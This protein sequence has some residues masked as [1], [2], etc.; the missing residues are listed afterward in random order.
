MDELS[1]PAFEESSFNLKKELGYYL[2]FWPYLLA[3]VL[4]VLIGSF[5]YLRYQTPI[6]SGQA[7]IQI[8][9]GKDD[10]SAFLTQGVSLFGYDRIKLVNEI[11]IITSNFMLGRVVDRVGLQT[12]VYV[13]GSIRESLQD[14][15]KLPFEV[16]FHN[17]EARA[18]FFI[19]IENSKVSVQ[20]D[21]VVLD[22]PSN[23][24][25]VTDKFDLRWKPDMPKKDKQFKVIHLPKIRAVSQLKGRLTVVPAYKGGEIVDLKIQGPN[26][27]INESILNALIVELEQDQVAEKRAVSE[28]SMKFIDERLIGLAESIDTISENTIEFQTTNRVYDPPTQTSNALNNLIKGQDESLRLN[29]QFEIAQSLLEN[30]RTQTDYELLPAQVGI[31]SEE[32]NEMV[33]QYNT[34][35]TERKNLLL[36]ATEINPLVV[37]LTRQMD[38]G[39]VVITDGLEKY[40]ESIKVSLRTYDKLI[41]QTETAV[42][43]IPEKQ[44]ELR[45]LSRNF[46]IVEELYYFL[47]QRREEASITYMSALPNLKVL[48]YAVSSNTPVSPKPRVTYLGAFIFGLVIPIAILYLLKTL[49]HKI[50]TREDLETGLK[51]ISI[52]G[53]VPLEKDSTSFDDARGII[54]EATRV[55]RSNLAFM[56]PQEESV[57]ISV[58][59]SIKGEGKSFVSYNLANS[60]RALGKKVILVGADLRNPQLHNRLSIARSDE[61]LSTYLSTGG[62]FDFEK[63]IT[64]REGDDLDY[65]LSG[66]IPPNP[67]ELLMRPTM[68]ELIKELK[69]HYEVIII[70]SAPLM[71]V[72]DTTPI[73]PL[74]DIIVYVCRS[75]YTDKNVFQFIRDLTKRK[76]IPPIGMVLNGIMAGPSARSRF[77]YSYRYSYN[78]QYNYGYGYGYGKDAKK[79]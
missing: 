38:N 20:L 36:S 24:Q 61:G 60:Y 6:Y 22:L 11:G 31:A 21:T 5:I 26:R 51:G 23:D 58:T 28:V 34:A 59:S 2:F 39:R 64:R 17:P 29:I 52:V 42:A 67:S 33:L 53:E 12:Q 78:Y 45:G 4:L 32:I 47:L 37:E 25:L 62:N 71:L 55:I 57:L 77:S 35:A 68:G 44:S 50:N 69:S 13:V 72:S 18:N 14:N 9:E 63:L 27:D 73:L 46:Q 70:D 30:L 79:K 75:Q 56:L 43:S 49:D 74:S 3:S 7:Q 8:K 1:N 41:A 15:S 65:L 66:A 10:P 19:N 40:I 54:A 16:T 76:N 48:S